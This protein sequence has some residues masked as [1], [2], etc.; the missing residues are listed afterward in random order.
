MTVKEYREWLRLYVRGYIEDKEVLL[1]NGELT[2]EN[3]DYYDAKI[4]VL[5]KCRD[6]LNEV[7]ESK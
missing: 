6:K 1:Y 2:T 5:R 4:D 7:E 3:R